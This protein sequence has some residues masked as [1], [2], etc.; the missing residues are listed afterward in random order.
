MKK[1]LFALFLV[2][3]CASQIMD[4]F[5]GQNVNQVMIKYGPP[6]NVF[7]VGDGR[8]AFQWR[9]DESLIIPQTTNYNAYTTGNFT[10][11]TAVTTGGY[12]GSHTCFYTLYAKQNKPNSWIVVGFEKPNLFC[13]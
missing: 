4:G 7:D 10:T 2:A 11:G 13:E 12:L 6:V 8:R 5:V 1:L 9:V 3:G